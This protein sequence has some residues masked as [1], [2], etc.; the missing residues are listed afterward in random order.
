MT[1]N[2]DEPD[3]SAVQAND[4]ATTSAL[5]TTQPMR[6]IIMTPRTDTSR[7]KL[8]DQRPQT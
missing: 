1:S 7:S 6:P 2:D 3:T 8:H 4:T 5:E